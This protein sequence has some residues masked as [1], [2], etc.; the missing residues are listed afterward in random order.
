M[1]LE[2]TGRTVIVTGAAHGFG[3]AISLAFAERGAAVWACD[4]IEDELAASRA[5]IVEAEEAARRKIERDIH[6]GVG[7]TLT[8]ENGTDTAWVAALFQLPVNGTTPV[9]LDRQAGGAANWPAMT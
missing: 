1:N 8:A 9:R 7:Q 2:F 6:D 4:V 3:R 5:R